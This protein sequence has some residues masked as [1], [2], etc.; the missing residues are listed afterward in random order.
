MS[1]RDEPRVG[2]A[3]LKQTGE[4][5]R[6]LQRQAHELSNALLIAEIELDLAMHEIKQS[7]GGQSDGEAKGNLETR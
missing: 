7:L 6:K 4:K 2:L 3:R 5:I 1:T